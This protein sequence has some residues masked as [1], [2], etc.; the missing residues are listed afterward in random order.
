MKTFK[1]L[2]SLEEIVE[3]VN[4]SSKEELLD[5]IYDLKDYHGHQMQFT[6]EECK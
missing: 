6:Y 4:T 3:T 1:I 5:I 2:N